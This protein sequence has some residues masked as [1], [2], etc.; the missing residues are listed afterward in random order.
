MLTNVHEADST[1]VGPGIVEV[2]QDW[3]QEVQHVAAL[4]QIRDIQVIRYRDILRRHLIDLFRF[5]FSILL[6]WRMFEFV[7]VLFYTLST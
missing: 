1:L 5:I 4:Q 2:M 7:V 6:F 3:H